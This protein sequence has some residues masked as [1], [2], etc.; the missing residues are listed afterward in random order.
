MPIRPELRHHYGKKWKTETRPRILE[1]D[2]NACKRCRVPNGKIIV[3]FDDLP[4]WWFDYE[5]GDAHR[6]DGTHAYTFRGSEMTDDYRI[7]KIVLTVAHLNHT[8]GDDRDDNLEALCQWH[9]LTL[10]RE[11]HRATRIDRKDRAR[12]LFFPPVQNSVES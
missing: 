1:R 9:H 2:G 8:A 12:T 11:Q 3:R 4:G 5:T 7:V 10:D 6:P